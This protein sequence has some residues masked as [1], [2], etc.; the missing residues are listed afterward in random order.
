MGT[1]TDDV[2]FNQI[3]ATLEPRYTSEVKEIIQNQLATDKYETLK[4]SSLPP[5]HLPGPE[6]AETARRRRN[7]RS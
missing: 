5:Q 3:I 6:D 1:N 7:W 4:E 2:K